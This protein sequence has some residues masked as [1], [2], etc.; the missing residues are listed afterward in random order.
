MADDEVILAVDVG[1]TACKVAAIGR[2]GRTRAAASVTYKAAGAVVEAS[3]GSAEQS[4]LGWW[5][6]FADATGS[7]PLLRD[8]VRIA[9]VALSGMMQCLC[10]VDGDGEPVRDAMLHTDSR[11]TAEAASLESRAG[12]AEVLR[13]QLANWK[14]ALSFPSRLRWL[15][16]H[17][18]DALQRARSVLLGAHDFVAL[19]LCGVR[20]ADAVTASTTG[21][22]APE[23]GYCFK[24]LQELLSD[25]PLPLEELLPPISRADERMGL[26]SAGAAEALGLPALA[27]VP[28]F[29]GCGDAGSATC[30]V[31][32]GVQGIPYAYMGTSGWVAVTV[33]RH[34][35]ARPE[36]F[37]LEH[38]TDSELVISAASTMTAGG[39]L[40]LLRHVFLEEEGAPREGSY[41]EICDIAA[42]SEPG[43]RGV[44]YMPWLMG[45]RS[46]FLDPH[47]RAGFLGL[48]LT[49]SRADMCRA[50]LEGVAY[51]YR[52]LLDLVL[53]GGPGSIPSL[54]IA[55]GPTQSPLWMQT[56]ADVLH[57]RVEVAAEAEQVGTRGAALLAARGLGWVDTLRPEGFFP[58]GPCYEP[59][60]G[61]SSFHEERFRIHAGLHSALEGS[62]QSLAAVPPPSGR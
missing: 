44:L 9:A 10:L 51:A 16:D 5:A 33:P 1:T 41:E 57:M 53:P 13:Q 4:P 7:L 54:I 47:A 45:E 48:S 29:H 56:F 34:A 43:S 22:L 59:D 58:R 21:L 19:R 30:G 42:G 39:N 49:T 3:E 12:G 26:V 46:P 6:A 28:V 15:L 31:G 18:P 25:L 35:P 2:D 27:G 8:D 60:E 50:V 55:G 36:A 37:R 23:G 20:V 38:P 11:A 32:A 14:G 24:V 17:Q 61:L 62:F 52:A 40:D